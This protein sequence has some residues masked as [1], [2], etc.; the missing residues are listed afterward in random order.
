L[1]F[2]SSESILGSFGNGSVMIIPLSTATPEPAASALL[3]LGLA[4]MLV[5]RRFLLRQTR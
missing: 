3:G 5:M 2:G 4:A 1:A